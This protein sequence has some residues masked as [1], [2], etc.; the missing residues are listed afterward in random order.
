[1]EFA[2]LCDYVDMIKH[3]NLGSS[4]W[5][6]MDSETEPGKNLFV[7]FYVCFDEMKKGWL[8]ACR[9]IIGFDG[10]FLKGACKGELLVAVGK[11]GNQQIFP[12]ACAVMDQETKH[13]WSFFI[14]YLKDDLHLGTGEGLAVMA[15]MK[16]GFA[17]ALKKILSNAEFR[18][19]T[20]HIWS[21]WHKNGKERKG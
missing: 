2:R 10:C 11:N 20:R 12:I 14:N 4:C 1:M 17:A 9:R 21:N 13:S 8:E 16:R 3:T 19:C 18:M 7:Y 5:V 6:R 15:D